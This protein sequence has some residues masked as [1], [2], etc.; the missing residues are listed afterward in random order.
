MH[1][2]III[3]SLPAFIYVIVIELT[4]KHSCRTSIQIEIKSI[5]YLTSGF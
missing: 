1:I 2:R 4:M 3:L 5:T